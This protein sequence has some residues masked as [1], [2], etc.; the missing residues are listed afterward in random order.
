MNFRPSNIIRHVEDTV[1]FAASG[2][3]RRAKRGAHEVRVEYRARQI[4]AEAKRIE[5]EMKRM[6]KLDFHEA[7][8]ALE[9]QMEILARAQQL[10]RER[11]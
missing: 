2:V 10:I 3:A 9:D 1:A 8:A 6:E 4:A 11:R 5:R 7:Q